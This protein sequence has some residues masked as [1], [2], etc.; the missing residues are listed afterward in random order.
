MPDPEEGL[1]GCVGLDEGW[2]GAK[3]EGC[4]VEKGA[5]WEGAK[6]GWDGAKDGWDGAKGDGCDTFID[7]CGTFIDGCGTFIDGCA[8]IVEG[9]PMPPNGSCMGGLIGTCMFWLKAGML[10][11]GDGIGCGV[12][13]GGSSF[14]LHPQ[15]YDRRCRAS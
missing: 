12:G 2:E 15:Y 11:N 10:A 5:G 14:K 9:S 4:V 13:A 8:G 1:F 6:D 3:G 7:G